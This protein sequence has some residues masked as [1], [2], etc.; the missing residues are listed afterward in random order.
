[1]GIPTIKDARS[2][3]ICYTLKA[4]GTLK[5]K[6]VNMSS[7]HLMTRHDTPSMLHCSTD[8]RQYL[9][10]STIRMTISMQHLVRPSLMWG[11]LN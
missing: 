7:H 8:S 3:G 1:M 9:N 10:I 11:M 4:Q 2:V 5:V 6:D